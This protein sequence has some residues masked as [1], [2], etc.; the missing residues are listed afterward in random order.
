MKEYKLKNPIVLGDETIE[1]L[2]FDE[3]TLKRLTECDVDLDEGSLK[4]ASGMAKLIEA[5]CKNA[6]SAHIGEMKFSDIAGAVEVCAG[7]FS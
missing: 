4:K 5:C 2:K 6:T 7:F 3:P 1:V